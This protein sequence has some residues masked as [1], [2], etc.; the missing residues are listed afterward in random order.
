MVM[1]NEK[2]KNNPGEE[3]DYRFL[4]YR[5]DQLQTQITKGL[6]KLETDQNQNYKELIQMLQIMQEGNNMQNQKL[7]EIGQRQVA[8]EEKIGC[9]EKLK[10]VA[11]SHSEKIKNIER[12][13]E[14]YKQI[15]FLIGGTA[16]TGL[17]TALWGV[18]LK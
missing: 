12:R 14:I 2:T 7:V 13:L 10:E 11:S 5:L 1:C 4:D 9:V 18:L 6:E 16:V 15:G 3:Y 8:M 17:L